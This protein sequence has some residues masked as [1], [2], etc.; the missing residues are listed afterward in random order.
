VDGVLRY[1]WEADQI[2]GITVAGDRRPNLGRIL[3]G[4]P[5]RGRLWGDEVKWRARSSSAFR[6]PRLRPSPSVRR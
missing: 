3:R 2:E 6:S 5:D 4:L 1:L